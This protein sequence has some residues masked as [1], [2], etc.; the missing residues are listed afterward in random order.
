MPYFKLIAASYINIADNEVDLSHEITIKEHYAFLVENMDSS[1]LIPELFSR[2]VLDS[3]DMEDLGL[4]DT[5]TNI[6]R[7]EK[8]L[9][10]LRRKSAQTF[11]QFI[12][13][14]ITIKQDFVV[15]TLRPINQSDTCHEQGKGTHLCEQLA[16][17]LSEFTE[18]VH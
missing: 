5:E 9:E 7:N 4:Q 10:S 17:I 12:S 16:V 3:K 11:Q 14:L 6:S 8:L 15:D 18:L 13:A 2:E 1:Q